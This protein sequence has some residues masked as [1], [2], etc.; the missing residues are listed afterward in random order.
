MDVRTNRDATRI[1]E[2][3]D[4]ISGPISSEMGFSHFQN[5]E[6]LEVEVDLALY[7]PRG[8]LWCTYIQIKQKLNLH[9]PDPRT[10]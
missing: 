8:A 3:K 10:K 6:N 4:E 7:V 5:F 2:E 1:A 9:I